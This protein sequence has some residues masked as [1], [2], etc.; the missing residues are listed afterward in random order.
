MLHL[1]VAGAV[2]VLI[3]RLISGGPLRAPLVRHLGERAFSG[4]FGLLS[5]L[6]TVW[7]GLAY[8]AAHE[9]GAGRTPWAGS[10]GVTLL[11][12]VLQLGAMLLIVPGVLGPTPTM[13]GL[14]AR[15]READ[16]VRGMLRISRHP[17]L[18]GV[19][20]FCGAHLIV[21]ADPPSL[22]LFG[23]LAF[24]ALT[25]TL[26]IDAKRRRAFHEAWPPF[27]ART[28]N[29]PFAAIIAGRQRLCWREI[30]VW[31]VAAGV[32]AWGLLTLAHP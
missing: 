14:G 2:F 25:G 7:L 22:V 23:V 26:S 21:T 24:V 11:V 10:P 8:A 5:L 4:G 6:A 1:G 13:A 12:A 29:V 31:R 18:W 3:H 9:P 28:S 27:A 20:I 17:F 15:L 30:G 32:A 19:T 16:A